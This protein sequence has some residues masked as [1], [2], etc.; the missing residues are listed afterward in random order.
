MLPYRKSSPE[1]PVLHTQRL[2]LRILNEHSAA[3]VL[4]YYVR[5]RAFHQPWFAS[6][7]DD[8]FTIRQQQAN[9]AVEYS[10]FLAGRAVPFWLSSQNEPDRII[11][12]FAF[13]N[14]VRGCFHSCFTAYH[15]DQDCQGSGL[16][17]EA[18]QAA[19]LSIFEDFGLHRVEANI[20][21]ANQRSRKLAMRLG[22]NLEGRSARYLEINGKW[23]D[24]LHYVR[25][26]DDSGTD[27][28]SPLPETE[29]L[30]IRPLRPDDVPLVM[31]YHLRNQE[32]I[33]NWNPVPVDEH[34]READ[35]HHFFAENLADEAAGHRLY[36]GLFFKDRPQWLAGTIE[37][38]NIAPLPY[39]SCEIGFSIDRLLSGRGLMLE[40]L[41]A[42]IGWLFMRYGFQ[43]ITARCVSGN[44]R[45]LRVLDILGFKSE[46]YER[47]AIWLQEQ[48]HDVICTGLLRSEFFK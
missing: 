8:V 16:A 17:S 28:P 22:F 3:A 40:A 27:E 5:N 33:G 21:P 44:E 37:C 23:E 45:S 42:T 1:L 34:S 24:H 13:T 36:L 12:R 14:I 26:A 2:L 20:M 41:S 19:L 25:L 39:S 30:L 9:L 48:W 7:S 32:Q 4:D 11:G 46:G 15:L 43:R 47:Q 35:W 6:R 10:D 38:K 18:G 31:Q 29:N